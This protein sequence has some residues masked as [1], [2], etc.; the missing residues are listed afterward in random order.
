MQPKALEKIKQVDLELK[1][2]CHLCQEWTLKLNITVI[3][4]PVSGLHKQL[5]KG[6]AHVCIFVSLD[7]TLHLCYTSAIIHF[8]LMQQLWSPLLIGPAPSLAA[9]VWMLWLTSR[10]TPKTKNPIHSLGAEIKAKDGILWPALFS[11]MLQIAPCHCEIQQLTALFVF[12][13]PFKNVPLPLWRT[14]LK[15]PTAGHTLNFDIIC[16]SFLC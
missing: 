13:T 4:L 10:C 1:I 16:V 9:L 12:V 15:C 8:L 3:N 11:L 14:R 2:L 5:M 7:M 6:F